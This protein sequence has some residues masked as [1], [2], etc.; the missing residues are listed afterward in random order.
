MNR[1][2]ITKAI[3]LTAIGSM[4]FNAQNAHGHHC[5]NLGPQEFD[6]FKDLVWEQFVDAVE[7]AGGTISFASQNACRNHYEG[8]AWHASFKGK[9]QSETKKLCSP[10][11]IAHF[12]QNYFICAR[13]AGKRAAMK[14]TNHDVKLNDFKN[15][16]ESVHELVVKAN[17]RAKK[18]GE[19]IKFFQYLC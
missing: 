3:P 9:F 7:E 4:L 16:I 5:R 17:K 19:G 8:R 11:D 1:R 2:E 6:K 12:E 10:D 13:M 15:A 18:K 14:A